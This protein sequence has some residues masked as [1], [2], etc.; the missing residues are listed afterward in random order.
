MKKP[1]IT[2]ILLVSLVFGQED[3]DDENEGN[4]S[5]DG[6]K[7]P[8]GKM[9]GPGG[10]RPENQCDI[11]VEVEEAFTLVFGELR[12]VSTGPDIVTQNNPALVRTVLTEFMSRMRI[13]KMR[14]GHIL[15]PLALFLREAVNRW[16]DCNGNLIFTYDHDVERIYFRREPM[17]GSTNSPR[18]GWLDSVLRMFTGPSTSQNT[19]STLPVIPFAHDLR[20]YTSKV[21]KLVRTNQRRK[22][23][24]AR[25]ATAPLRHR[26]HASPH[27]L[28]RRFL[29]IALR[30]LR[31]AA[32]NGLPVGQRN[33]YV[34]L[35]R[36]IRWTVTSLVEEARQTFGT[37]YF[38][39][40][41][42]LVE[43]LD[44][45]RLL[46]GFSSFPPGDFFFGVDPDER[47]PYDPNFFWPNLLE[48]YPFDHAIR[49]FVDVH[50]YD[51]LYSL[52]LRILQFINGGENLNGRNLYELC[53]KFFAFLF[54][55]STSSRRVIP[56]TTESDWVTITFEEY[57]EERRNFATAIHDSSILN[58]T[59]KTEALTKLA[60]IGKSHPIKIPKKQKEELD[61]KRGMSTSTPPQSSERSKRAV[62]PVDDE[63]T[64]ATKS[65]FADRQLHRLI[66]WLEE[67]YKLQENGNITREPEQVPWNCPLQKVNAAYYIKYHQDSRS[68]FLQEEQSECFPTLASSIKS[69]IPQ[70]DWTGC[71]NFDGSCLDNHINFKVEEWCAALR[72]IIMNDILSPNKE[73]ILCPVNP[74]AN[75]N[76][77]PQSFH[78]D[79]GIFLNWL[80]QERLNGFVDILDNFSMSTVSSN[81]DTPFFPGVEMVLENNE[82]PWFDMMLC[83]SIPFEEKSIHNLR[84]IF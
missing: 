51:T 42:T 57:P 3:S 49:Y 77:V 63:E 35:E 69:V 38:V 20:L 79:I 48:P 72:R 70:D 9:V 34:R 45:E 40:I 16:D 10:I 28:V 13:I 1:L 76:D 68:S 60:S 84:F 62:N 21:L 41:P 8:K 23:L 29:K 67:E 32:T 52:H 59:Q 17:E 75:H 30:T 82:E 53:L 66:R 46:E 18:L 4:G 81:A 74:V 65:A 2:L 36:F 44:Y 54:A 43:D 71:T 50:H 22:W 7:Y 11:D 6:Y 55:T 61:E 33:F 37:N 78:R 25:D 39:P 31:N 27:N 64:C 56:I 12:I 15:I 19:C 26:H 47:G 5:R 58:D 73:I 24:L 80:V 14:G 83:R